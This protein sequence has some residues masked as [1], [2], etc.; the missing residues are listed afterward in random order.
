MKNGLYTLVFFF[1]LISTG[2]ARQGWS[3]QPSPLGSQVLGKVQ[4]VSPMEGWITAGNGKLLHTT[5]AGE[6]WLV[7]SPGGNDTV[8]FINNPA[9]GMSF[10][11]ASTGWVIGGLSGVDP[12]AVL[13]KTTN[14]G[15]VWSRQHLTPWT[16]GIGVQFVDAN[17]GWAMVFSG[18]FPT[19]FTAAII[20][21]TDGGTTWSTQYSS[22]GKLVLVS[23]V[24]SNT[25][26]A[27]SDS[28][29]SSRNIICPCEILRTTNAGATWATQLHDNTPGWFE[30]LQLV[31]QT[32]GW[33]V[34]DSA[35]ILHTTDGGANWTPITNSGLSSSSKGKAVFFLNQNNGW[36][37][38]SISGVGNFVLHTT[39]RGES[40]TSNPSGTQYN[41]FSISFIDANNGWLSADFGGIAHS[42]SGGEPPT[43]IPLSLAAGWNMVSVPL[44]VNDYLKTSLFPNA[45]SN[46][47]DYSGSYNVKDTLKNGVGYWV[48]YSA[49]ETDSIKG[50]ERTLDTLALTAGWNMIGSI[51]AAVSV[52]SITT[53]PPTIITSNFFEYTGSYIVADSIKPG[54]AYWVYALEPGSL[55]LKK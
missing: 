29:T 11:S 55:I 32:D 9:V 4:F 53:I 14:G 47:F 23:F 43:A 52:G 13:Y 36:I 22:N 49:D 54:K 33:V 42:I 46:A 1:L 30:A 20:H 40:W 48:M 8:G 25:G 39:N 10:I 12:G 16:A 17:N 44:T 37:G 31:N 19:N 38:T 51:S 35:K 28:I 6:N 3:L 24:D 26:L 50:G 2:N 45:I 34:G 18:S 15:G 41:V 5:N 7:E 21:T 27:V